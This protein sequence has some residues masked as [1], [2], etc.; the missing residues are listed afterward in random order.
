MPSSIIL[1]LQKVSYS[2]KY[3]LLVRL[4]S[5]LDKMTRQEAEMR[6]QLEEKERILAR[7]R[8]ETDKRVG[9]LQLE[10]VEMTTGRHVQEREL[11][12]LRLRQGE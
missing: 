1:I 5:A 8:E 12:M 3:L 11:N 6:G 10:I 2:H 4:S 9:E 7:V